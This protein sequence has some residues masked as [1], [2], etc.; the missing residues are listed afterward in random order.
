MTRDDVIKALVTH[1]LAGMP[2]MDAYSPADYACFV[3]ELRGQIADTV[4]EFEG[5]NSR[6][7]Q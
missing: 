2:W 1:V 3:E 6:G 7:R 4:S 5:E